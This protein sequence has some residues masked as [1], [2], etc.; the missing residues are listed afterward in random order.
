MF[1]LEDFNDLLENNESMKP[2][3]NMITQIMEIPEDSLTNTTIESI[4]GAVEGA[5]TPSLR[6]NTI[7]EIIKYY[8]A[9]GFSV[10]DIEKQIKEAKEALDELVDELNPSEKKRQLLAGVFDIF[11]G[12]FDKVMN[13][14]RNSILNFLSFQKKELKFQLMHMME[15]PRQIYTR[16]RR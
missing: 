5:F 9:D 4:L 15:T 10:K 7:Q 1:E 16:Q 12:I 3:V 14:I 2:L 6:E 13:T 11:Y 8:E